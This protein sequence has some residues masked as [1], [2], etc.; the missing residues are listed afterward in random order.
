MQCIF[1]TPFSPKINYADAFNI[2]Y[3]TLVIL[4]AVFPHFVVLF[5]TV[6]CLK[7]IIITFRY[8]KP[9]LLRNHPFPH[10]SFSLSEERNPA[11]D[12]TLKISHSH[13]IF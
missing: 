9:Q 7:L 8:K 12:A 2:S 5:K 10:I 11:S 13:G 1:Q 3:S 4:P 6:K